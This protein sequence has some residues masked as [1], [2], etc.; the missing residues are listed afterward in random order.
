[1]SPWVLVRKANPY[2]PPQT[3]RIRHSGAQKCVLTNTLS[4]SEAHSH[5]RSSGLGKLL[6][7]QKAARDPE[8]RMDL[9]EATEQNTDR[10]RARAPHPGPTQMAA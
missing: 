1:M 9:S 5:G 7:L 4:G 6:I 10:A 2:T 8:R 3:Y